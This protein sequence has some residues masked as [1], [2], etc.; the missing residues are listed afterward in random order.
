M[1]DNQANLPTPGH[2]VLT[3][4]TPAHDGSALRYTR[5]RPKRDPIGAL[6][7]FHGIQSHH[8]WYQASCRWFADAGWDVY[9]F[10][11]RGSG[12][13]EQRRGD[14][15]DWRELTND[16]CRCCEAVRQNGPGGPVVLTTISWG[17]KIGLAS[18]LETPPAVDRWAI[19]CPGWFAKVAPSFREKLAIG[20]SYVF[21]PTRK[22]NVPLSDPALFTASP[23]AQAFLRGDA[24][25]LRKATARLLMT[26][27]LLD[28]LLRKAPPKV[29]IPTL[30]VLAGKDRII[31]NADTRRF[32]QRFA[33]PKRVLD[34]P[35][36]S[37]T[38][39]FEPNL[40]SILADIETWMRGENGPGHH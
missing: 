1:A 6:A 21:W 36:A 2:E 34:Y 38:L 20:W 5:Y 8:G 22:I 37:H 29:K 13:N 39:E 18:F 30:L 11:R 33:G 12:V 7:I 25:S 15:R 17:G 23:S 24:L 14:C 4:S 35:E 27:K 31:D 10:D 28:G 3:G 16:I 9:F 19:L 26:S 32:Y 40:A